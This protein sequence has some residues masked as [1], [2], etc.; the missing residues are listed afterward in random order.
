M[1]YI[2]LHFQKES[3]APPAGFRGQRFNCSRAYFTGATRAE[4][5]DRARQ[6]LAHK[7][8]IHAALKAGLDAQSAEEYARD[9]KAIADATDWE[10]VAQRTLAKTPG[11]A[12][13]PEGEVGRAARAHVN[14]EPGLRDMARRWGQPVDQV[15]SDWCAIRDAQAV[16]AAGGRGRTT[17]APDADRA[18]RAP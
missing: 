2:A 14:A 12:A 1:R 7:R 10:L 18:P 8:R 5:R 6:S 15:A 11:S 9:A 13:R 16:R 17:R 4:A 3:Q